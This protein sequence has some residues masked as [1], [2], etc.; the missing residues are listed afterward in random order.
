MRKILE[1]VSLAA[2]ALMLAVTAMAFYGPA[3]L[4]V[5]I[6]THFNLLGQPDNWGSSRMLLLFPAIAAA[7]YLMMTWVSRYPS[8]FN[9]PV[10]VTPR[11]RERLEALALGMIAWLK[12][13]VVTFLA[14]IQGSAIRAAHH[15][16]QGFSPLLMPALLAAVFATII[17]HIGA[18][19]MAGRAPSR[20]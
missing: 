2:L 20:P 9:F 17:V 10:R 19:F 14:W 16:G 18:M 12:A 7:I 13:E 5:R 8:A 6:P 3:H 1:A 11:N 15:P 4:P